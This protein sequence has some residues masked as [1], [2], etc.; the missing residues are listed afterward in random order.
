MCCLFFDI[1]HDFQVTFDLIL[2]DHPQKVML[3]P[4]PYIF[5]WRAPGNISVKKLLKF[6]LN[7][8]YVADH[9][10]A[11]LGVAMAQGGGR[12]QQ[13]HPW[14]VE[15]WSLNRL[16]NNERIGCLL[17]K[18]VSA[19]M[20]M[21]IIVTLKGHSESSKKLSCSELFTGAARKWCNAALEGCPQPDTQTLESFIAKRRNTIKG[22]KKRQSAE[23]V[24]RQSERGKV[25][26]RR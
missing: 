26:R 11:V 6:S 22:A 9:I 23:R 12:Y 2:M 5:P 18:L 15:R 19:V 16:R 4:F 20:D 21:L 8:G 24:L 25:R 17:M 13:H 3:A 10:E 1:T 7:V 14:Q